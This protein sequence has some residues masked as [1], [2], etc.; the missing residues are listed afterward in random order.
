SGLLGT[1]TYDITY[2]D[3]GT[4]VTLLGVTTDGLGN[5]LITG[6]DAGAYD[7]W[8]V[9]L[10]GCT[11]SDATIITLTDPGAPTYM[12]AFTSDPLSCGAADGSI[13]IS[14]LLGT[15]T[16][17]ITYDDDGTLITLLG[18]TTDGLG[19]YL[20][21]GL[22][23]GAYDNWTVT[24]AGC[25]GSDAT[26]ITL[27]DP[28]APTFTIIAQ[29][30]P[31]SCGG[32]DGTITIGGLLGTTTYDITYD[33]DGTLVTLLGVTT[34]GL[35]NF[36]IT[37]ID[38]GAYDNWT[39]TLAGC[40]GTDITIIT[41]T[42]PGAPTFTIIAQTDPTSC[43]G[44]DGTITIG[45]LLGTTTYDITYDDDGTLVTLLGVTTDGLGNFIITG[46]DAGVYDNWTISLLGC[47]GADVTIITL[48]DPPA[49]TFTV[50]AA[51]D[52]S[53][54]DLNDG[55]I[56]I[57]GLLSTTT[58][59]ISY[60]SAG[61]S[62]T[63]NVTTNA[64]GN[65]IIPN[66]GDGVYSNFTVTLSGCTGTDI[67]STII[68]LFDPPTPTAPA[69]G[70]DASICDTDPIVDLVATAGLGG[71]LEWYSDAALTTSIGTGTNLTPGSTLGTSVYYV[72]ETSNGCVGPASMVT[73]TITVCVVL[74]VEIPTGFSPD[75][76]GVN[77]TWE[78]PNL[79]VVY[80]NNVVRVF[81]RW[82]NILFE[83]NGYGTPWDGQNNGDNLPTGSYFFTID[84]GDDSR[85]DKT[86]S[87]TIIR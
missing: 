39:V 28:G 37:G 51:L 42:D 67:A 18:V 62:I 5:Y 74:E 83:S 16:Y 53:G 50:T 64:A 27:S 23:A 19:D 84:F 71:T 73:I 4:M 26:I 59:D 87:V 82:G 17:D 44:T 66:L 30:N 14:G 8:T 6:L 85:E 63:I 13:T 76:D 49:P 24:L 12:V 79:N 33:D 86:G 41:L 70:N 52:P 68:T 3:D 20:I 61:V 56:T 38:A 35:G 22:D 69:A 80:P 34:D 11:G 55:S 43:G 77:D 25:T 1:T 9:T 72:N 54:C 10:A 46:L 21:T 57:F 65:Y 7:N 58:Y 36:I 29:T 81:N 2:D 45:G 78:I 47:T 75:N 15:T 60:D 32:T 31:T 48:S 40:T